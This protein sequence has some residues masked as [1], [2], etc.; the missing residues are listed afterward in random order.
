VLGV[1]QAELSGLSTTAAQPVWP[2]NAPILALYQAIPWAGGSPCWAL[3]P[4]LAPAFG[5]KRKDHRTALLLLQEAEDEHRQYTESI[6]PP[7]A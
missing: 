4:T 3:F 6:R 7:A 2:C 1:S 5:I